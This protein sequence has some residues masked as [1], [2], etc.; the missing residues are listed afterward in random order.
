ME[1]HGNNQVENKQESVYEKDNFF[2]LRQKF[3]LK[4][5]IL[6]CLTNRCRNQ[7]TSTITCNT[8]FRVFITTYIDN[9]SSVK[10]EYYS[11]HMRFY[12][13]E[14]VA[15][16]RMHHQA[17]WEIY[18][19]VQDDIPLKSKHFLLHQ[20]KDQTLFFNIQFVYKQLLSK[21]IDNRLMRFSTIYCPS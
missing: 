15:L 18:I 17:R 2:C 16:L 8:H 3:Y 10:E 4:I 12:W 6:H 20:I 5:E 7:S 14:F 19:Q 1:I 9:Q 13:P 11:Y 21:H